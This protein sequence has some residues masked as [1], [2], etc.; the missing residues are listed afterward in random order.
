MALTLERPLLLLLWPLLAGALIGLTLWRRTRNPLSL[1]LRLFMLSL[2]VVGLANPIPPAVVAAPSRRVILVDRSLSVQAD[3][4]AAVQAAIKAAGLRAPDTLV[5]QFAG[6]PE[7]VAAPSKPWPDAPDGGQATNLAAA[8]DLA[9]QLLAGGG[10]VLLVSDGVATTGDALAAAER[11]AAAG[12]PVDVWAAARAPIATDAAVEGVD[13]PEAIWTGEPFSVSVRLFALTAL[14]VQLEVTRDGAA[15]AQIDL[16]LTA[17]E[18]VVA[19]PVTADA[20]GLTAFEARV[21]GPGDERPENDAGGAVALVRPPPAILIAAREPAAAQRLAQALAG[22]QIRA[23][24]LASGGLPA[25]TAPLLAYDALVLMDVSAEHL[26]FEQMA[27]LEAYVYANGRGLIVTG[28][29]ASFSLGAYAGT[30]LERLLPISL[31]P[32]ERSQRA[33]ASLVLLIDRS[34]SMSPAKLSLVKEAAMRAVEVLQPTDRVGVIAFADEPEW[35]VPLSALGDGLHLRDVLDSIAQITS[36][37]GTDILAPLNEGIAALTAAPA[38]AR[39]I[40]LFSDGQSANGQLVDFEAL[41]EHGQAFDITVST[42]AVG[43]EADL[44]LME[45]IAAWGAG[46]F[47]YADT[48]DRIPQ[49]MLAEVQAVRSAA[50]QTG[51]VRAQITGPHPLVSGFVAEAL[52]AL[53]AYVALS[54][55]PPAGAEV[56]LHSPLKD[57]LLATWQYGLGRVVAWTSDV[58]GRWTPAWA[59]WPGLGQ[60]WTQVVRYALPSPTQGP[61]FALAAANGRAVDLTVLAAG[62]DGNGLNLAA[63]TLTLAAPDGTLST[64][65]VP[66]TAPGEYTVTFNVPALGA[67]RGLVSVVKG[68][69]QWETPVG[70]VAG[71][72]DEFN[73]RRPDGTLL[74]N[75]IAALTGGTLT[76]SLAAAVPA[77]PPTGPVRGYGPWLVLAALLFWPLEIAVRRRW[78]P[79]KR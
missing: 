68:A 23:D 61:V 64:L 53:E 79:W 42:I 3:A 67:Y 19:L 4:I 48:P 58:G 55:R 36:R 47:H 40:V 69:D 59:N 33:P 39:H 24:L 12:L 14:P 78:M 30:P 74:L 31:E 5:V 20:A 35:L 51:S 6:K 22:H 45:A 63:V 15:L 43:S 10:S 21:T 46:R 2:L 76:S 25:N 60:F 62:A 13:V 1:A 9:G 26:S 50:V 44:E 34:G 75:Q 16:T 57:P 56:V 7:L 27:A 41:V 77:A 17:G 28:G 54:A 73:A 71:Y 70:L 38:G 11:L 37:G 49:M 32:P 65:A 52:P 8:L 66:Q 18:N 29:Q 72:S